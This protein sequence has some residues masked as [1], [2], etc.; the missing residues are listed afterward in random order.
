MCTYN[1]YILN[2]RV[3]RE[4]K[5]P[6]PSCQSCRQRHRK[7]DQSYPLPC[8]QCTRR[9]RDCSYGEH[10][11]PGQ[12]D[13]PTAST[14]STEKP[15]PE[16]PDGDA[17]AEG[18]KGPTLDKSRSMDSRLTLREQR[19]VS[20]DAFFGHSEEDFIGRGED[21]NKEDEENKGDEEDEK[22]EEDGEN[23]ENGET[24][25]PPHIMLKRISRGHLEPWVADA[26]E[27]A[28]WRR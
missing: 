13:D 21:V 8:G 24:D 12:T 18:S 26:L 16:K 6:N 23:E 3:P 25:I 7:C 5:N 20:E 14:S 1:G 28:R 10:L 15:R 9:G 4:Y 27:N 2:P 19:P 11:G 17:E 22:D